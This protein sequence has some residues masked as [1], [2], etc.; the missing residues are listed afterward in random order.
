MIIIEV[1]HMCI[2]VVELFRQATLDPLLCQPS[3]GRDALV[4]IITGVR[5][6]GP[7][8]SKTAG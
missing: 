5:G 6:Q 4:C 3:L 8:G 1:F 2:T 7:D